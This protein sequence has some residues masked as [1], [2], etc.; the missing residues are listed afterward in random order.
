MGNRQI[1][2]AAA[3]LVG[4]GYVHGKWT[5]RWGP[6]P[7]IAALT[8]RFESVPM[9]I[10]DWTATPFEIGLPER[11]LAGAEA[12]LAR[13]YTNP[14]RGATVSVLLIGGLP[15]KI[16]THTPEICYTAAGYD[17]GTP[18]AYDR[19]YSQDGRQAHLRTALA[20]RGL[21]DPD[22]LRIF[23]TWHASTGWAAPGNPAWH[24]R[25]RGPCASC[26]SSVRP[27]GRTSSPITTPATNSLTSCYPCSIGPCSPSPGRRQPLVMI[28]SPSGHCED[29]SGL[30]FDTDEGVL[31]G[32]YSRRSL[33]LERPTPQGVSDQDPLP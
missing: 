17:L 1:I 29:Y 7:E 26:T 15:G 22:A 31:H 18:S 16:S 25:R 11:K 8:A 3:F 28:W 19:R 21:A 30:G 20:I 9:E 6:S 14:G 5:N 10:G 32:P 12:Y 4:V 24:S 2:I 13:V 23:W 27:V 33:S